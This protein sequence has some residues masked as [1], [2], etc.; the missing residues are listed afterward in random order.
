MNINSYSNTLSNLKYFV[1]LLIEKNPNLIVDLKTSFED[2]P[3]KYSKGE[4]IA[5]AH[6]AKSKHKTLILEVNSN[7]DL[8]FEQYYKCLF[9]CTSWRNNDGV[10]YYLNKELKEKEMACVPEDFDILRI[11]GNP[12]SSLDSSTMIIYVIGGCANKIAYHQS[13]KI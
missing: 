7:F 6:K 12:M 1:K 11:Q 2:I 5:R 13:K 10:Y 3:D 8:P 9:D 4:Y